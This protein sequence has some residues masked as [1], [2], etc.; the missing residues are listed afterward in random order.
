MTST[1]A[2]MNAVALLNDAYKEI[3]RLERELVAERRRA[4]DYRKLHDQACEALT[5]MIDEGKS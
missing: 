1:N 2:V 5:T 4:D 3:A